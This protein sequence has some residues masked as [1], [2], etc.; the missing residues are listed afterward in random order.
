[1]KNN[2]LKFLIHIGFH[3]C[4]SSWL[5]N[6]FFANTEVFNPITK[7]GLLP[8]LSKEFITDPDGNTYNSFELEAQLDNR[9]T[10][11]EALA[12]EGAIHVISDERLSGNPHSGGL[13]G[14]QI[15][16]RLS[17]RI[18][19]SKIL[20]V[21]REQRSWLL[22]NYF[23]YLSSGGTFGLKKYLNTKYDG[24][25]PM[26]SPNHIKYHYLIQYYQRKFGKDNVIILPYELLLQ[27]KNQFGKELCSFLM[28]DSFDISSFKSNATRNYFVR[29]YFRHFNYFITCSSL[30]NYSF[31]YNKYTAT[32]IKFILKV[33]RFLSPNILD[34]RIKKRLNRYINLW[35]S[36]RY[37]SSN[38]ITQSLIAKNLIDFGYDL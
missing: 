37:K 4:A 28:I 38:Q 1:M 5:Q 32:L 2:S 31:L 35:M 29:Y 3:K 18:P 33:M 15:A 11:I 16:E 6:E 25:I 27:D 30:N 10:Q 7:K 20:V 26:F 34:Q 8:D 12:E 17:I 22:S 21:I 13:D 19:D 24:K 36:D 14:K 9:L 23:Q